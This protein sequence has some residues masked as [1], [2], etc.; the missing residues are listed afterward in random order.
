M[1]SISNRIK[2]G[3]W[4]RKHPSLLPIAQSINRIVYNVTGSSHVLPN[5]LI[6][7][8]ARSGTTSL[9]E[10]LS[11]H[12]SIIQASI[13]DILGGLQMQAEIVKQQNISSMFVFVLLVTLIMFIYIINI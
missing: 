13:G 7:G 12:P 5:F 2:L 11:K 3:S 4:L 8:A 6:I 10:Y 9:Y 1:M